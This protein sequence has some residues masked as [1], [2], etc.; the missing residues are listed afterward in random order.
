MQKIQKFMP[1]F[2]SV[3]YIG[4]PAAVNV[5]FIVSSLARIGQ[6]E[7][8][9]RYDP[10]VRSHA[11]KEKPVDRA[12]DKKAI[13]VKEVKPSTPSRKAGGQAA[14]RDTSAKADGDGQADRQRSGRQQRSRSTQAKA[15][16]AKATNGSESA[17]GTAKAPDGASKAGDGAA[18]ATKSP[19]G[20]KSPDGTRS[21]GGGRSP[22]GAK[23]PDG[24]RG[25]WSK[26]PRQ[27]PHRSQSKRTR[28]SR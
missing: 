28:K 1:L 10:Q 12:G 11:P 5:Y 7:L 27:K 17:D 26:A 25:D 3:I 24:S 8:M 16:E 22:G 23:A 18:D 4:I 6:Q 19:D 14:R 21:P 15:I 13:D 20:R 9:F 2:F